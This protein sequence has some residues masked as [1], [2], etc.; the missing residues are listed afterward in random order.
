[1]LAFDICL[2]AAKRDI[3]KNI[4]NSNNNTNNNKNVSITYKS[5]H[6]PKKGYPKQ[7]LHT[8]THAHVCMKKRNNNLKENNKK[9]KKIGLTACERAK[10]RRDEKNEKKT[11]SKNES[12]IKLERN[13]YLRIQKEE[14]KRYEKDIVDK[15]KEEPKR[16]YRFMNGKIKQGK[17][18]QIEGKYGSI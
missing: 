3:N 5:H 7:C 6:H 15:C 12:R 10:K 16:F 11:N 9:E 14:E 4:K 13:E 2:I 8:H 1:M 17:Y 18:S